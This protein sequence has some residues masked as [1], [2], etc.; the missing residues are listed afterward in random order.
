M[1]LKNYILAIEDL[2][3]ERDDLGQQ[4]RDVFKE[5]KDEGFDVKT[6]RQVIKLRKMDEE[7]RLEEQLLI[8]TYLREVV[9]DVRDS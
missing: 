5:A 3:E 6:M 8:E 7:D 2:M 4:I 1:S 9:Q